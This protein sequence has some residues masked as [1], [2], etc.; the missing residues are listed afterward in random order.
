MSLSDELFGSSEPEPERT[1]PPPA[2]Q[3]PPAAPPPAEPPPV[4]PPPVQ[5]PPVDDEPAEDAPAAP[6]AGPR[7]GQNELGRIEVS[8]RAVEKIAALASLEV[9]NAGGAAGRG[10]GLSGRRR[11]GVSRIPKVKADV[12]GGHVFLD[13][14]LSV[15]WPASIFE[16]SSAVRER[17]TNRIGE[18]VGLQVSEVNIEVVDLVRDAPTAR[19]S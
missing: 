15:R 16:V 8:S 19:V 5:P 2:A 12:D 1:P 3:Q 18:L 7:I 10:L 14:E 4:Q 13:V 9:D 11:P 6:D 17:L